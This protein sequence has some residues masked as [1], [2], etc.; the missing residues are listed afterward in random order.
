MKRVG[1][2]QF[3]VSLIT[4]LMGLVVARMA[5]KAVTL[6][7]AGDVKNTCRTAVVLT[8]AVTGL[9]TVTAFA[10]ATLKKEKSKVLQ[11]YRKS[12][13]RQLFKLSPGRL[14]LNARGRSMEGLTDDLE[15]AAK[16]DMAL[17]PEL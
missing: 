5:A 14:Y 3:F 13:Y 8:A 16:R 11:E 17:K 6:A 15:E 10:K 12:L 9:R 7:I 4:V 1:R 2:H